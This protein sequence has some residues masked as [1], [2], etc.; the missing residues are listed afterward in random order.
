MY[1]SDENCVSH[2]KMLVEFL[3]KVYRKD[4]TIND[5]GKNHNS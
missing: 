2:G 3:K 5:Q 1:I 4:G